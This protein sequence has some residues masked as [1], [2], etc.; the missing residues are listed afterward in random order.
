MAYYGMLSL[1]STQSYVYLVLRALYAINKHSYYSEFVYTC[2]R[3]DV[4]TI[5]RMVVNLYIFPLE[6]VNA[7]E[8]M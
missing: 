7:Q 3:L 2:N 1:R 6:N 5:R 8:E 4:G